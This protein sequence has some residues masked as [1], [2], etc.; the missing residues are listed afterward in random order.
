MG[1]DAVWEKY[2]DIIITRPVDKRENFIKDV[3][4]LQEIHYR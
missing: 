2:G 1:R 4:P 3:W